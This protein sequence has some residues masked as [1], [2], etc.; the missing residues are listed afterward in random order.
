MMSTQPFDFR[1]FLEHLKQTGELVEIQEPVALAYEVGALCR[2]LADRAGPAAML[3]KI[4]DF[5]GRCGRVVVNVYGERRRL[6][7]AFRVADDELLGFV[8]KRM[9]GRIDPERVDGP[10]SCQ[11]VVLTGDDI[12]LTQWPIPFWNSGD[13]GPYI[14]AGLH[15]VKHPEFGWNISYNRAQVYNG[16]ELG[17]CMAP[18]H[19]LRLTTDEA[20]KAGVRVEAA[21]II[22]AR[23]SI[24][25]A[26]ASDLA[27]G[28]YELRAAG[29]LEG[30]AIRTVR[31][32]T[33]DVEVPADSEIVI[34]GY[35]S[36]ETREE[37]PFVE[38]T[39]YQTPIITSPVF[40]VTAITHRR[41]PI[42]QGVFA[43]RPPCETNTLWRELE[44]AEAFS[45]LRQK[46][47]LLKAVH[48]PPQVGRDFLGIIQIDPSRLREGV[49]NTLL[50]ATAAV[51]PRLKFIIA[52]DDDIDL[53]DLTAVF[54]A[55]STRCD[56]RVDV[57][58]VSGTMTSWL[59]PSSGGLTGKVFF[60]A[61]KKPGFRGEIPRFPVAAVTRMKNILSA[62]LPGSPSTRA[63]P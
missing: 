50:L 37:G 45:N 28:D 33:V 26:A 6:A 27:H 53:Y 48:R 59:D 1:G 39:G 42:Y 5:S 18:D 7:K 58:M 41:D 47:P 61:T 62:H 3:S 25:I 23:P 2:E 31:C 22:G 30:V 29:A 54:W 12:D 9:K 46:F 11:E 38:F 20:R 55:V 15:I 16:R 52:V 35:Y 19:H 34:E 56:P 44:E 32:K 8:S 63:E 49:V 10:A 14:T 36:G 60:N 57:Q 51:M 13:G 21:I 17:V 40:T 43:G 24:S 4:G